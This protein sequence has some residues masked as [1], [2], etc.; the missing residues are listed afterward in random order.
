M[1]ATVRLRYLFPSDKLLCQ[2]ELTLQSCRNAQAIQSDISDV[3]NQLS[4]GTDC[5]EALCILLVQQSSLD[6]PAWK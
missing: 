2:H 6:K 5:A 1:Q 3:A 4:P